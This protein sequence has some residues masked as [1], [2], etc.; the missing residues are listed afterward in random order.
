M[1][2][3]LGQSLKERTY[4]RI[5]ALRTTADL[6]VASSRRS[7]LRGQDVDIA[8]EDDLVLLLSKDHK[9]FIL[10]LT[11]G[12]EFHS[13]R[14][15]IPHEDIIGQPYGREI[16]THLGYP[17][18]LLQPSTHD[19]IMNVTRATQIV[20]PKE[21][22]YVLLKLSIG[23]GRRVIEAGTGSG[24]LTLAL[25][26]SVQPKGRVYSYED[27]EDMIRLASRNLERVGLL[28]YVEL[29]QRDI[30]QGFDERDVDACF[31]DVRTPWDY[32]AQVRQALKGGGF[33]GALVPTANQVSALLA[34]LMA[35][36]F[37]DIEAAEIILRQY[38]TVPERLRPLDRLTAHTGYLIFARKVE[39]AV[40]SGQ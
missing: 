19:L 39:K 16:Q 24:A 36:D 11:A 17:F 5:D 13:H 26:H 12:G 22:G 37:A 33:F 32:L 21:I 30:A 18:L 4:L 1:G 2:Y 35:H 40:D 27:R 7:D 31:L 10:R 15:L 38:K 34:G 29:K 8:A 14:G 20:Y 9:R 3:N 28:S 6:L 23:P 25:A